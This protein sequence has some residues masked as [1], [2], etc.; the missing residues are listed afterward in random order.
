MVKIA[1]LFFA[2]LQVR[3]MGRRT[4]QLH[5]ANLPMSQPCPTHR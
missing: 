5:E 3:H 4:N 2:G 1:T